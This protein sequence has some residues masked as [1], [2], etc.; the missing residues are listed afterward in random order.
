M[1]RV[2]GKPFSKLLSF[3]FLACLVVSALAVIAENV[4]AKQT[5]DYSYSTSIYIHAGNCYGTTSACGNRVGTSSFP[6][7]SGPMTISFDIYPLTWTSSVV[8][9][10]DILDMQNGTSGG[11]SM[12]ASFDLIESPSGH[13]LTSGG[14]ETGVVMNDNA[15]NYV[16][17]NIPSNHSGYQCSLNNGSLGA[18]FA[19]TYMP[20]WWVSG[21]YNFG[22]GGTYYFQN[23]LVQSGMASLT[24]APSFT[25]TPGTSAVKS[26]AYSYVPHLNESGT[27]TAP[28]LPS[29]ATYSGGSIS[30][31]P[32]ATGT[33][34]FALWGV[35]TNGTLGKTQAWNVTVSNPVVHWAPTFLS[36][37]PA[38]VITA[39]VY[40]YSV[41]LNESGTIVMYHYPSGAWC[42]DTGSVAQ[43]VWRSASPGIYEFRL[44]GTSSN[45]T[46]NKSQWFNV[47]VNAPFP[48]IESNPSVEGMTLNWYDYQ[49]IASMPCNWS[50]VTNMGDLSINSHTGEV[51]GVP[52]T[53]G[54]FLIELTAT[55]TQY[56]TT[57][58]QTYNVTV[59]LGSLPSGGGGGTTTTTG[60][61]TSTGGTTIFG[62]TLTTTEL[63]A[64][65][66]VIFLLIA[67]IAI[68]A[69]RR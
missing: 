33:F 11:Y 26:T 25:S 67:V 47:T 3:L 49:P 36:T 64:I 23:L 59:A 56:N 40:S 15:W 43:L 19:I 39:A 16:Q 68:A 34:A 7:P 37:P 6:A 5:T 46:F 69:R 2:S 9:S 61:T 42:N 52:G 30:W 45:G 4:S 22:S 35:S 55:S 27:I 63:L 51:S 1:S 60:G 10:C 31:T 44:I 50:M 62:I 14:A 48:I 57:G 58:T 38:S 20:N 41:H 8:S 13:L 28:I 32:S 18:W 65:F 53:S 17:V 21:A 12:P 66:A 29:G 54:I 24:W